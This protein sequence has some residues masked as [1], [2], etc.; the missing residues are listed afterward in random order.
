M[1][2]IFTRL[3]IAGF[4]SFAE[5][6]SIEILPG[7]TGI[8]GP[9]GCG[10]S[11]VVEA[12]RWAMGEGSARSLRGGEMDDLI[13]AGTAARPARNLAEVMLTLEQAAGLAPPPLHEQAELQVGRRIER[14]GGS[15]YRVNGIE[16][17]ARDV[18]TLFADLASGPRA[19]AM[20]SQGRVSALVGARPDERRSVLEE[21][22]GITGLHARRHEAEL[23]LRATE[24]NLA[25]AD[26]LRAGLD[27]RI[28]SLGSQAAQASRYRTLAAELR[29]GEAALLALLH[30]RARQ[31][32][33]ATGTALRDSYADRDAAGA[34]LAAAGEAAV[35]AEAACA[36]PRDDAALART[37]LERRRM[38]V[39]HAA[40]ARAEADDAAARAEALLRQAGLD[41]D[42]AGFRLQDAETTAGRL[43][44]DAADLGAA[45]ATLP[46]RQA[47]VRDRAAA[48]AASLRGT[49][50]ASAV[51]DELAT[52][53]R[54]RAAEAAR[55]R[56]AAAGRL[57]R[58]AVVLR[59][60][61]D[62]T[63]A[64]AA[65]M[66]PDQ[67]AAQERAVAAA[68]ADA[69]AAAA[70]LEA[71][72]ERQRRVAVAADAAAIAE[73]DGRQ[74][75]RAATAALAAAEELAARLVDERD[76]LARRLADASAGSL[77]E[78]ALAGDHAAVLAAEAGLAAATAA[79]DAADARRAQ[80]VSTRLEDAARAQEG[81]RQRAQAE[82]ALRQARALR[83]RLADE[84]AALAGDHTRAGAALVPEQAISAAAAARSAAEVELAHA[85]AGLADA[86][87]ALE[88]AR[89]L[90]A[91]SDE[92]LSRLR[93]AY[94][95]LRA[96]VGGLAQALAPDREDAGGLA[97]AELIEIPAGLEAALAACL[98][99]GL[100]A[101]LDD[102]APSGW[103]VLPDLP[104]VPLPKSA[105]PL[106]RLVAAPPALRRALS[107]AGLVEEA[108]GLALQA[109]LR[110]G[111]CLVT[112]SG[113]LWRWDGYRVR[114]GVPSQAALRLLQRTRLRAVRS[115]LAEAGAGLEPAV[116][117]ASGQAGER[118]RAGDAVRAARIRRALAEQAL[119]QARAA[120]NGVA[121][122]DAEGRAR[123]D[124]L[125]PQLDRAG[126]ALREAEAGLEQVQAAWAVLSPPEALAG[127]LTRAA[128]DE[129][130]AAAAAAQA[131]DARR[132]AEATLSRA[133][134]AAAARLA[135]H[136]ESA[137]LRDTLRPLLDRT[138]DEAAAALAARTAA[139]DGLNALEGGDG[140]PVMLAATLQV[141][142]DDAADAD[143]DV[144]AARE[145]LLQARQALAERT[146]TRD[147]LAAALLEG[148][149]RLEALA[150]RRAL[151]AAERD[152]AAASLRTAVAVA[153]GLPDPEPLGRLADAARLALSEA[154]A[155]ERRAEAAC[156]VLVAEQAALDARQGPLAAELVEWRGRRAAA[157]TSMQTATLRLEAA[158]AAR[159]VAAAAPAE[160]ERQAQALQASVDTAK[161]ALGAAAER[162]GRAELA[163][164]AALAACR[165]G[166]AALGEAREAA[167][168]A[169]V[170]AEQAQAA[171][172][173]LLA[174]TP[175]PPGPASPA[176]EPAPADLSDAAETALRRRL[177][178]LVRERDE[179][180]PVN[181]RADLELAEAEAESAAIAREHD[182]L[183]A[184]IA[185]LRGQIGHLNREG[186]ERLLAVFTAVDSHFQ[187]LFARMFGGGRAQ[188]GLVGSDDPLSAGLEIYAQPPG[189]RLSTL[190]LLSGGEQ[191]LTA[192][193][194]IFAV[195]RC[196]PA[197]ICVLD[198]VDAPLDDANVERFCALLADMARE[199]GTRYLVVTHHQSTMASM[200]RLYGVTMQERGVSRVLSVDL[201]RAAEMV[202]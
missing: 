110:P 40:R 173:Q 15:A 93:E 36:E 174:D 69:N 78:P 145:R 23:K 172:A 63:D 16:L 123:M 2:A 149:S 121:R 92:A 115:R 88:A 194:L 86:D 49:E 30:A 61:E 44:A 141:R 41:R 134:A 140:A 187:A 9:N 56:E 59:Q 166:E 128:A 151:A 50:Q 96:E 10:K 101:G 20:V 45:A 179:I 170:R 106:D 12:L 73:A 82:Q 80:A 77:S 19:S 109:L 6:V 188:L 21:A 33:V 139:R 18:Q 119:S 47:A 29:A 129:A 142:R 85:E 43:A 111:Q 103:H 58:A 167:T 94:G 98:A 102:S 183:G 161:A 116:A 117:Q 127:A 159:D 1:T 163:A 181:L 124:A 148:R 147:R 177:A 38:E 114:S 64:T 138:T 135:A 39:E 190:S 52:Q 137:V 193:S 196:N 200:D 180:G 153:A 158:Q 87:Q 192:L 4:K 76:G 155:A 152:E 100:E 26:D 160:A 22:A 131:R 90:A 83:Q 91:R 176:S 34:W 118:D 28:R 168:R 95:A 74:R 46:A 107:Q 197:P 195:F 37:L 14:G 199:A 32:V 143:T 201:A 84:R 66:R 178:R 156:A 24:G 189:K 97:V 11:N 150:A 5:P 202:G 164:R 108:D 68:T 144:V 89:A 162:L 51:A 191:A 120:E 122:R 25:R 13:F 112:R 54:T 42:E 31:A 17:R 171:L 146:L 53:A 184:A 8:V 55:D 130:G 198:E 70:A 133:R 71:G 57:E 99:D 60:V 113:G 175:L 136:A 67:L 185:R 62:E 157:V 7:L 65:P 186:R 104:S 154:R 48:E 126:T 3:R 79:L 72:F 165:A 75:H 105:T 182:E 169:E 125:R 81:S 132:D 27:A 35:A